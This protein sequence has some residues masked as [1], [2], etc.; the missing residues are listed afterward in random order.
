MTQVEAPPG[1]LDAAVLAHQAIQPALDS[2]A[3]GE[4]ADR[5]RQHLRGVAHPIEEPVGQDELEA[6]RTMGSVTPLLPLVD[7]GKAVQTPGS[8]LPQRRDD[9]RRLQPVERG[10]Q[11]LIVTR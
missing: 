11:A 9:A 8:G 4:I 2:A 5:Q 6:Q 10:A 3:Q 7:P 1:R